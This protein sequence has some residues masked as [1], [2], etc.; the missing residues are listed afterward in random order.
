MDSE[1]PKLLRSR[2]D[3]LAAHLADDDVVEIIT[4]L[5]ALA[6]SGDVMAIRLAMELK[7]GKN[8][9][10]PK[11]GQTLEDLMMENPLAQGRPDSE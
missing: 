9:E 3:L 4:R 6:L 2:E 10:P 5:K 1:L 7:Y 8:P 11:A